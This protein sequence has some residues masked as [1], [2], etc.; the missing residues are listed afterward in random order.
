MHWEGKK[1]KYFSAGRG[2]TGQIFPEELSEVNSAGSLRQDL[3]T[4]GRTICMTE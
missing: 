4:S 2:F 3:L 1:F